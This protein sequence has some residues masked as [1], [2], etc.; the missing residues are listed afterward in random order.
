MFCFNFPSNLKA[1][2]FLPTYKKNDQSDIENIRPNNVLPAIC[3]IY[4]RCMYDKIYKY[5]DQFFSKC[6]CGFRQSYITQ[7]DLLVMVEKWKEAL[8]KGR[9]SSA[10]LTGL[11]KALDCIKHD[12]LITKLAACGFDSHSLSFI[13]SYFNERKQ[14]TK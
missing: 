6:Q 10:R 7:H 1:I 5:F 11:S 12:F 13:F 9:L 2:D 8:H 3:K 4:E 14:R